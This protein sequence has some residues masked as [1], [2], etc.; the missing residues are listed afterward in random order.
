MEQELTALMQEATKAKEEFERDK[1]KKLKEEIAKAREEISILAQKAREGDAKL[2]SETARKLKEMENKVV[3]EIHSYA[4]VPLESLSEGDFV[5][6]VPLDRKAKLVRLSGGKAEVL[7]GEARMTVERE[8]I[9]GIAEK[10]KKAAEALKSR[11]YSGR[12]DLSSYGEEP[13][14]KLIGMNGED[15]VA[16]VDKFLDSQLL[17]GNDRVKVVHGRSVLRGKVVEY[18]KTSAY[19]KSFAPGSSAEGGDAVSI[20]E[21]KE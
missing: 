19:V 12:A 8:D 18:L 1:R 5:W 10:E 11:G 16:A 15:A 13:E 7:C 14:I 2:K 21:L 4:S 9:V 20:V 3:S 17:V 6:I